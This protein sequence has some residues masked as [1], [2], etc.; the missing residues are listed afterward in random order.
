MPAFRQDCGSL[1]VIETKIPD[2]NPRPA[3]QKGEG[4]GRAPS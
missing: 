1:L 4:K 3:F 2:K